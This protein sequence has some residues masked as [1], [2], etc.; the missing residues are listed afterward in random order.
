MSMETI[1]IDR[2]EYDRMVATQEYNKRLVELLKK[3]LPYLGRSDSP[4]KQEVRSE[5]QRCTV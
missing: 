1:V 2:C 4:L 3:T 5:L